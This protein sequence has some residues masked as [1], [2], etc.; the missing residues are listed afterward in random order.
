MRVAREVRLDL[1][2]AI[3]VPVDEAAFAKQLRCHRSVVELASI[4]GWFGWTLANAD[5]PST[6]TTILERL[7]RREVTV[8]HAW[9]VISDVDQ[10]IA[11]LRRHVHTE[12][13]R[14]A[15]HARVGGLVV[16]VQTGTNRRRLIESAEAVVAGLEIYGD[17]WWTA[18]C[19]VNVPMPH[20]LGTIWTDAEVSRLRPRIPYVDGRP[21]H[22]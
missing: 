7:H 8:V 19:N 12:Q 9:D 1:R 22:G 16:V 15:G 2:A 4:G 20:G 6:T 14:R 13:Q 10:A 18:L 21:R 3:D 17:A 5:D 11:D